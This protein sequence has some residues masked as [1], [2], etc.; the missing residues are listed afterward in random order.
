M[1]NRDSS[2][3]GVEI[4]RDVKHLPIDPD[5]NLCLVSVGVI[6]A[7]WPVGACKVEVFTSTR[8][9]TLSGQAR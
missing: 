1:M 6:L 3:D 5:L 8:R 9:W 4:V 2:T 7:C